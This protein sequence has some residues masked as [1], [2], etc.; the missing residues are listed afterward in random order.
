MARRIPDSA[1]TTSALQLPAELAAFIFADWTRPD[2]RTGPTFDAFGAL[3]VFIAAECRWSAAVKAWG[4]HHGLDRRDV[5][6]L[7]IRHPQWPQD[8]CAQ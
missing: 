4:L 2:D 5:R 3:A 8:Y 1:T 7:V 6:T